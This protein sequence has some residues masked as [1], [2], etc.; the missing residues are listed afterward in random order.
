MSPINNRTG[1]RAQ[2]DTIKAYPPFYFGSTESSHV[3]AAT[4]IPSGSSV[5]VISHQEAN[6]YLFLL[7]PRTN[8]NTSVK[9]DCDK[10]TVKWYD[11][12]LS[13]WTSESWQRF[14]VTMLLIQITLTSQAACQQCCSDPCSTASCRCRYS[15]HRRTHPPVTLISHWRWSIHHHPSSHDSLSQADP[16]AYSR[17][18]V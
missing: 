18:C 2:T 11:F 1:F 13:A 4:S 15:M 3:S 6:G 17:F 5:F 7:V 8:S 14:S 10:Q 9:W 12:P 16:V